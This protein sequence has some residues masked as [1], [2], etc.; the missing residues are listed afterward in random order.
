MSG[1]TMPDCERPRLKDNL[2]RYRTSTNS[3]NPILT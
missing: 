1:I 2:T 3:P